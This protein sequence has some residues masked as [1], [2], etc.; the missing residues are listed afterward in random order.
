MEGGQHGEAGAGT[1]RHWGVGGWWLGVCNRFTTQSG[2]GVAASGA[3]PGK[4]HLAWQLLA[5]AVV[6]G[7]ASGVARWVI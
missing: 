2:A 7:V 3:V 1:G 5:L 4:A 6:S